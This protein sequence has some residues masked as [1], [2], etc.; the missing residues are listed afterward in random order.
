MFELRDN[1]KNIDSPVLKDLESSSFSEKFFSDASLE[2]GAS[3]EKPKEMAETDE[4]LASINDVETDQNSEIESFDDFQKSENDFS[5]KNCP[6]EN[7]SWDGERGDSKWIP[8]GEYVPKKYNPDEKKWEDILD[9]YGI[10]GIDYIEGE[11]DFKD[12]SKGDVEIEGFS[13]NRSDNYDKADIELAK[14]KGC[15]PSEVEQWRTEHKYTWHECKDMKTMQKVPRI[16]HGNVTHRGG[17]SEVNN[18]G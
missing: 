4:I 12:I 16:V 1:E 2:N 6:I 5:K 13:N 11:P 8:D 9:K 17:V 3:I 14:Q 10:D 7:G 15:L 18:G